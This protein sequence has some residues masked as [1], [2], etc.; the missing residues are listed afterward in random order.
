MRRFLKH[1]EDY[2]DAVA[3]EAEYREHGVVPDMVSFEALRRENSAIR[4]CFGLFEFCFG[5]DL[6]DEVFNDPTF[7]TL[8]WAAADM[9]CWSNVSQLPLLAVHQ[10]HNLTIPSFSRRM[11]TPTIWSRRVTSPGSIS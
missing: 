7:S 2:I 6:P 11:S 3:Q 9:V 1:F 4:P 8:Y 10:S 5:V